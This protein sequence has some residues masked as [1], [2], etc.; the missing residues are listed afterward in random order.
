[1][2]YDCTRC[3]C[4]IRL[5]IT[6]GYQRCRQ[7]RLPSMPTHE[8]KLCTSLTI[9][10]LT[11]AKIYELQV[12]MVGGVWVRK[13]IWRTVLLFD[14]SCSLFSASLL[15]IAAQYKW[16]RH[17]FLQPLDPSQEEGEFSLCAGSAERSHLAVLT[18]YGSYGFGRLRTCNGG[19]IPSFLFHS[20][21][22][23]VRGYAAQEVCTERGR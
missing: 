11:Y 4:R 20:F 3:N 10:T 8:R 6:E 15:W 21:Q 13:C 2:R 23:P 7:R 12:W 18:G 9:P 19:L 5:M 22:T 14:V 17:R 16:R 1:M